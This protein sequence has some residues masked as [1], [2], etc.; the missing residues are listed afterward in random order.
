MTAEQRDRYSRHTL[1]PEVGVEGQLKLLNAKVLLVGAGGLG[2]PTALYLA[3]AGIGTLGLV[4]DDV[5]DASNLQRQVIHNTERIGMPKTES[6]RTSRSRR[7]T[8]TSTWS[9]TGC[10][11]T[12]PTSSSVIEPTTT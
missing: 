5:V 10:A 12:P 1:L 2:A 11:L 7:S 6:A 8:P 9:S 3:A 4:D